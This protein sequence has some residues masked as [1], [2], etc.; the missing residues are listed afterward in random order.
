MTI[1]DEVRENITTIQITFG[2]ANF[3]ILHEKLDLFSSNFNA[4]QYKDISKIV[5]KDTKPCKG[6]SV[7]IANYNPMHYCISY[8]EKIF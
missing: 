1:T 7:V 6:K 3:F 5:C 2:L 8:Y 4:F